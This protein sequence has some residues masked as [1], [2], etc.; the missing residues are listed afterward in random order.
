M[1]F[2]RAFTPDGT[3]KSHSCFITLILQ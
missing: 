3:I 1:Y 2:N